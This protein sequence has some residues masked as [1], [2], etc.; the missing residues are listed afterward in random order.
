[1]FKRIL[2]IAILAVL[3]TISAVQAIVPTGTN[4]QNQ[5]M[6]MKVGYELI[7]T[8]NALTAAAGG[9]QAN[10]YQLAASFSRFTV[11]ATAADSAKLQNCTTALVGM[12]ITVA[13]A[14]AAD[15][16]NVFPATGEAINLLAANTAISVP[17]TKA[18]T[19]VCVSNA[20]WQSILSG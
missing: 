20:L 3:A 13:N 19:F 17:A 2:P 6:Y 4:S 10:A 12:Q 1:M 18:M 11:V 15:A 8:E 16:M 9:G 5:N 7:S 14:D